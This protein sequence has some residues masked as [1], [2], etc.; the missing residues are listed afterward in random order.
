MP[1]QAYS[2]LCSINLSTMLLSRDKVFLPS[3][4]LSISGLDSD[5]IE[6]EIGAW[7]CSK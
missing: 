1:L 4:F 3:T 2:A 6:P 5:D 7:I